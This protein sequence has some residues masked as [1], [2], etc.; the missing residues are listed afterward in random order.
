MRC[1]KLG[2]LKSLL[3]DF[4]DLCLLSR[5]F[6][7]DSRLLFEAIT[8]TFENRKAAFTSQPIMLTDPHLPAQ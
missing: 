3:N 2:Q 8:R 4:F 5:R 6:G 1:F 7:C